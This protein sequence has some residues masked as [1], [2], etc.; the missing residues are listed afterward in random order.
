MLL[1]LIAWGILLV[2]SWPIAVLVL[3][4]WPILWLLTLPFRLIGLFFGAV[5][6][7]IA[8]ILYLPARLLGWKPR[9]HQ[10]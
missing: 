8:A 10:Q 9:S 1:V 5:L 6:A 2:I 7:L 4:V 3:L